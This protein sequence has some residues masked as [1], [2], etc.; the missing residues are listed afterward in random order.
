MVSRSMFHIE[1]LWRCW[2]APALVHDESIHL[3]H[4]TESADL[5]LGAIVEN[6]QWQCPMAI[7][8]NSINVSI[9]SDLTEQLDLSQCK[10]FHRWLNPLAD[11]SP[12]RLHHSWQMALAGRTLSSSSLDVRRPRFW[13]NICERYRI[14]PSS[15]FW[16]FSSVNPSML[17]TP[18][19]CGHIA[20]KYLWQCQAGLN[21]RTMERHAE[22][23][24]RSLLSQAEI[25]ADC[26]QFAIRRWME[27]TV[28]SSTLDL[29]TRNLFNFTYL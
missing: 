13:S 8:I 5:W 12:T 29:L 16:T 1:Y 28:C 3:E 25:L 27:D 7:S 11:W 20:F 18:S 9:G 6:L 22:S 21:S 26:V 14:D 4:R 24:Y 23:K 2:L 17:R 15:S 19:T 10:H